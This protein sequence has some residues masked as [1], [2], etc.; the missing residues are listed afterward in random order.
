MLW[1]CLTAAGEKLK[2]NT[3]TQGGKEK[4]VRMENVLQRKQEV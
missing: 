1:S 4:E 3:I 2:G